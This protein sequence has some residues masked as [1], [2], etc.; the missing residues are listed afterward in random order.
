MSCLSDC[1]GWQADAWIIAERGDS[2]QGHVAG[3]LHRP[4]VILLQQQGADQPGDR[5]LLWEDPDDVAAPFDFVVQ[6]LDGICIGYAGAGFRR[7]GC[8][9]SAWSSGNRDRGAWSTEGGQAV[10]IG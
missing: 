3:A 8:E 2:F 1:Q 7:A 6:R 10:V 5:G 4:L 9:A